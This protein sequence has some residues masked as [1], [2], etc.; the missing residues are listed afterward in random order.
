W[1]APAR[2]L[3]AAGAPAR[4]APTITMRRRLMRR[5]LE[6]A[7]DTIRL[8]RSLSPRQVGAGLEVPGNHRASAVVYRSARRE[9]PVAMEIFPWECERRTTFSASGDATPDPCSRGEF[10]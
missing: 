9:T 3:P 8:A 10:R 2:R 4:E 5:G 6:A 7:A 1:S